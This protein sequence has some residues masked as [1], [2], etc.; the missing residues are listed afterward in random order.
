MASSVV[1]ISIPN[2]NLGFCMGFMVRF[3]DNAPF[4]PPRSS[5]GGR[6]MLIFMLWLSAGIGAFAAPL[7]AT[8]FSTAPHWTY[9]YIISLGIAVTNSIILAIVF[10]GRTQ[11]GA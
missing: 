4:P 3:L 10:K 6:S 11:D 8:Y 2:V 7:A 9:H 5:S 1:C